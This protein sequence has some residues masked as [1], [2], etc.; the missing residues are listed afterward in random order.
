[1]SESKSL[2]PI[3]LPKGW[4]RKEV[5]RKNGLS[6]GKI[7]VYVKSPNGTVFRSQKQLQNYIS[8]KKIPLNITDFYFS[9]KKINNVD[10]TVNKEGTSPQ[11]SSS[12][13]NTSIVSLNESSQSQ[14]GKCVVHVEV[15]TNHKS[16]A[17]ETNCA[18][19][20]LEVA[21]KNK[22][23]QTQTYTDS[24]IPLV[25]SL[26]S[27]EW[28][29]DDPIHSYLQ[30]IDTVIGEQL[31]VALIA[32]AVSMALKCLNDFN[33]VLQPLKL[34]DKSY[35]FI[36]VNDSESIELEITGSHWSLLLYAKES[37]SFYYYDSIGNYNIKSAERIANRISQTLGLPMAQEKSK[38]S[39]CPTPQQNN[40]TDCGI[41]MILILET[42][43]SQLRETGSIALP[44]EVFRSFK[45]FSMYEI[46]SKKTQLASMLLGSQDFY[47][48]MGAVLPEMLQQRSLNLKQH[49]SNGQSNTK[50]S[51]TEQSTAIESAWECEKI[52]QENNS[53][54][55]Q[56]NE[57][58]RFY[59]PGCVSSESSLPPVSVQN[60]FSCLQENICSE[61]PIHNNSTKP[62]Q[63]E[64]MKLKEKVCKKKKTNITMKKGHNSQ[65]PLN[66]DS[67]H[68]NNKRL[69]VFADS[70]G[71]E[72]ITHL[73][74]LEGTKVYGHIQPGAPFEAV[75]ASAV[76][77]V[78]HK[79]SPYTKEDCVVLIGGANN[80]AN[81]Y[82]SHASV[83]KLKDH[84]ENKIKQLKNTH[85][86]LATIPYRYDLH[87][88]D[89]RNKNI[90]EVNLT[91]RSLAHSAPDVHILDLHLLPRYYHTR[92]G[93]HINK[94]GKKLVSVMLEKMF[95]TLF[96]SKSESVQFQGATISTENSKPL[97][98]SVMSVTL[99]TGEHTEETSCPGLP[100]D[101]Y[102]PLPSSTGLNL[103]SDS[104]CG[105]QN[106]WFSSEVVSDELEVQPS[107]LVETHICQNPS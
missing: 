95:K 78:T 35:I 30:I 5:V 64:T 19:S 38:V 98:R 9:S 45:G 17:P 90:K 73:D 16:L 49:L 33:A 23:M 52:K 7:D 71:R 29:T 106:K 18:A 47:L 61:K 6:K 8:D 75:M 101:E 14:S 103:Q 54:K 82:I 31:K 48:N 21:G 66:T 96:V 105:F 100:M 40:G 56:I 62:A 13:P 76:R 12:T 15:N 58:K 60:Y 3:S 88:H 65:L 36:P 37:R 77:D 79:D 53:L 24:K 44:Q 22:D 86:I 50:K 81:N 67:V 87:E 83:T 34:H 107:F 84:M 89:V 20:P 70:H 55:E 39:V 93:F 4:L 94:R 85:L 57:L 97:T 104:D 92:N 42:L 51:L 80:L 2:T 46:W 72:L 43:L 32:P 25:L 69:S 10:E 68:V 1:M 26:L 102:P 59:N 41:F 11:L 74:D 27:G 99:D 63:G 91:I 28:V